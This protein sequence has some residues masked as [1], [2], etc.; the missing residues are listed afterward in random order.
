MQKF[1]NSLFAFDKGRDDQIILV[2]SAVVFVCSLLALFFLQFYSERATMSIAGAANNEVLGTITRKEGDVS[3]R[4]VRDLIFEEVL[5]DKKIYRNDTIFV[6]KNS[7]AEVDLG[8]IGIIELA[9]NTL[10]IVEFEEETE[11]VTFD[12]EVTEHGVRPKKASPKIKLKIQK[13]EIKVKR[14]TKET[15]A[16]VIQAHD[17]SQVEIDTSNEVV[18]KIPEKVE[19]ATEEGTIEDE[20]SAVE[21]DALPPALVIVSAVEEVKVEKFEPKA[22]AIDEASEEAFGEMEVAEKTFEDAKEASVVDASVKVELDSDANEEKTKEVTATDTGT[23]KAPEPLE[24]IEEAPAEVDIFE[25][26]KQVVEKVV[27]QAKEKWEEVKTSMENESS[28]VADEESEESSDVERK[29]AKSIVVI[30]APE[31]NPDTA[32][33][34]PYYMRREWGIW[35]QGGA[36]FVTQQINNPNAQSGI[37]DAGQIALRNGIGTWYK[38]F[39]FEGYWRESVIQTSDETF[40]PQWIQGIVGY[41]FELP[42]FASVIPQLQIFAGWENYSNTGDT[43]ANFLAGYSS[44]TF[45][46]RSRFILNRRWE[47]GG[48]VQ[49]VLM[50]NARKFFIQG[51]VRYWLNPQWALGGGYWIDISSVTAEDGFNFSEQSYAIESYIRYVWE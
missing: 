17:N 13:G 26:A 10:L 50:S 1:K 37:G 31:P 20:L 47:T 48:D 45:G 23:A 28:E 12:D 9:S 49:A 3:K 22:E 42:R 11:D 41:N 36:S 8:D 2:T 29:P 4:R 18:L 35:G 33:R 39:L 46:F 40:N 6:D 38:N 32:T 5:E 14:T 25:V 16:I 43:S 21:E 51:D 15:P 44:P 19:T 30:E 34:G 24:D 7:T 27:T